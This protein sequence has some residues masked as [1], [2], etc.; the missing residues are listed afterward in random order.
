VHICKLSDSNNNIECLQLSPES[1]RLGIFSLA[2]SN[3]GNHILGGGS[4]G[5]LYGYDRAVNKRNLRVKVTPDDTPH[6]NAVGFVDESSQI[7][8]SGLDDGIIKIW[9]RRCLNETRPE[10]AGLLLGHLDGITYI[11]SKNDGRHLISN[12]K[13]QSIKLWDLRVFSPKDK[14]TKFWTDMRFKFTWD[15]RWD[16][17]PK[18]CKYRVGH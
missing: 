11:D 5:C 18:D 12:S 1:T 9:D 15:Y 8:Y 17:V 6:V 13:D 16:T 3:C 10:P 14:E 2:F 4:D 7:F